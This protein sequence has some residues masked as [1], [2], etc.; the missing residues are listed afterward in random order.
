MD[1]EE[2]E[3]LCT[4]IIIEVVADI[5]S[6]VEENNANPDQLASPNKPANQQQQELLPENVSAK[7][8]RIEMIVGCFK[9]LY[10]GVF[11]DC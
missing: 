7:C 1:P 2:I 4:S 6:N 10:W 3:Q 8:Y 11:P 9:I 5:P